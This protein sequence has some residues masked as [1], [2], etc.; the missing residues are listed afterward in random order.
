MTGKKGEKPVFQTNDRIFAK[1]K[2]YP[3]WPA[4]VTGPTDAK[5]TRYKVYFYGTYET[6]VVK[7]EEMWNFNEKTKE[8]FGKQKRKGFAEAIDEIENRPEVGYLTEEVLPAVS[9]ALEGGTSGDTILEPEDP[10][11]DASAVEEPKETIITKAEEPVAAPEATPVP[12]AAPSPI[13]GPAPPAKSADTQPA[14]K[15]AKRKA[16]ET[17]DDSPAPAPVAKQAKLNTSTPVAT[18]QPKT[19]IKTETSTP[20]AKPIKAVATS[21]PTV[22]PLPSTPTTLAASATNEEK[23]S[24]SGRVIKPKKFEDEKESENQKNAMAPRRSTIG[25]V[26]EEDV[27]T[28]P[29]V[30]TPP[31]A[32]PLSPVKKSDRKM[33]VQIKAT[34]DS[35]EINMD[36][37]RPLSFESR[38]DEVE[39]DRIAAKNAL[40][41]KKLVE[42]GQ[43]IP[44]EILQKLQSK[45]NRTPEEEAIL[46]HNIEISNIKEKMRWMKMEKRIVDLDIAIRSA[47]RRGEPDMARSLILI[48]ELHSLAIQPLMLKKLPNIV[49]TLRK[50]RKYIGPKI[51]QSDPKLH[52]KRLEDM[53]KIRLTAETAYKKIQSLFNAPPDVSFSKYFQKMVDEFHVAT[54]DYEK[55]ELF[56][57]LVDPTTVA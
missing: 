45:V 44:P 27:I 1:V 22:A 18:K 36:K 54:K 33:W 11:L 42:S 55:E 16:P 3:A 4:C 34:S 38:A 10:G 23:T 5:G 47:L 31:V 37:D 15:A 25:K 40:R 52:E 48:S 21:T 8:K 24:R 6:A 50:V 39:W 9:E 14:K 12:E 57:L 56:Q 2:G 46:K 26:A 43:Y 30:A 51:Q 20:V 17:G 19:K 28:T 41:L 7:R 49:M 32:K 53:Q 35:I 13:P 29:S